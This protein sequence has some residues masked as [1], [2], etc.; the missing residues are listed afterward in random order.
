MDLHGG[1]S[2]FRFGY[3]QCLVDGRVKIGKEQEPQVFASFCKL[4]DQGDKL[5]LLVDFCIGIE[6]LHQAADVLLLDQAGDQVR[7]LL[8]QIPLIGGQDV[9]QTVVQHLGQHLCL[10]FTACFLKTR[11]ILLEQG[12]VLVGH[13]REALHQLI[14]RS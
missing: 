3:L 8:I 2:C 1:F 4:S 7:Q 12:W 13:L 10:T 5:L 11:Q 6:E 14:T 9:G